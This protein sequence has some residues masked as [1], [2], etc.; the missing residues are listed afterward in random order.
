MTM[1]DPSLLKYFYAVATEGSL[2]FGST[3]IIAT[4]LLP[5]VHE[6]FL[7]HFPSSDI[8]AAAGPPELLNE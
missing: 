2:R 1:I 7:S 5:Q 3:E 6:A 4:T 8:Y